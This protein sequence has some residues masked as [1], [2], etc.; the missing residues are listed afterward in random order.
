MNNITIQTDDSDS[1]TL[2]LAKTIQLNGA[3]IET[4]TAA[5]IGRTRAKFPSLTPHSDAT[6]INEIHRSF[7]IDELKQGLDAD[8]STFKKNIAKAVYQAG[9]DE[10]NIVFPELRANAPSDTKLKELEFRKEHLVELIQFLDDIADIFTVPLAQ[11]L[12]DKIRKDTFRGEAFRTLYYNIEQYLEVCEATD[13]STPV[14]GMAYA[15]PETKNVQLLNRQDDY[16][17]HAYCLDYNGLKIGRGVNLEKYA[18]TLTDWL[19]S[20]DLL[21]S[22]LVYAINANRVPGGAASIKPSEKFAGYSA[23][24]D[25]LGGYHVQMK[26]EDE[27]DYPSDDFTRNPWVFDQHEYVCKESVPQDLV[28]FS[29]PTGYNLNEL[30]QK[31]EEDEY[32]DVERLLNPEQI[33]FAGNRLRD[34][35]HAG[36][37]VDH[38]QSK[39]GI[40]DEHIK[41]FTDYKKKFDKL[42]DQV[43]IRSP[44]SY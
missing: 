26:R 4:P 37:V 36:Q 34:A 19:N 24:H 28:R 1:E 31:A 44:E 3:T 14:M 42:T 2:T 39:M 32:R 6:G 25:I 8:E 5:Q 13:V 7:T 41:N 21:R 17:L 11:V 35:I 33:S 15:I 30:A 18:L 20:N 10:I 16:N 38:Y 43:R 22:S 23:G 27:D 12:V 9:D 40:S 29:K